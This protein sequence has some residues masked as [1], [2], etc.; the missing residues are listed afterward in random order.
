MNTPNSLSAFFARTDKTTLGNCDREPI[1]LS[2]LVQDNCGLLILD[3]DT[4]VILGASDNI[5][6]FLN[7]ELAQVLTAQLSEVNAEL[8]AELAEMSYDQ[9]RSLHEA[10][11]FSLMRDGTSHDTIV[12]CHNGQLFV[13]FLPNPTPSSN[14]IR[15]KMR[16]C[17]NACARIL[18]ADDWAGSLNIAVDAVR[19]IT[20]FDRV[21]IYQFHSDWS[22]EVI[23]ESRNSAVPSYLGLHFPATDIPK[24]AREIMKLLPSRAIGS[25]SD[26]TARVVTVEHVTRPVDLT[27][28]VSRSVSK[29]HTAYLRNMNVGATFYTSLTHHG[30]LWGLISAH[31]ST[32]DFVPFDSWSL[33]QEIATALM[34]R[35]DQL[36]R[37]SVADKIA[38]LRRIENRF[39]AALRQDGDVER[40][41]QTLVP[42]LQEFLQA[43]GFAFQYG[44]KLH[45]SGSTPPRSFVPQLIQ[46]A[47]ARRENSDQYQTTALHREWEPAAAHIDTA[48]GVLIQPIIMHRVCQLIWF[49]GPITRHVKWAGEQKPKIDPANPLGVLAPRTSFDT[50][51]QEHRDESAPWRNSGLESAREIFKEFLDIIT[52]QFLLKEEN[53]SLRQFAASAA[54]DLKAPLR[55]IT[56]A[57]DIMREEN[58]DEAVVKETHAFAQSSAKRLSDLTSGLL[59]LSGIRDNIHTFRPTDLNQVASATVDLLTAQIDETRARVIIDRLPTLDGNQHLLVRLMLNL[60]GNGLKYRHPDRPPRVHVSV[61]EETP[62]HVEIAFTDNGMGIDPKYTDKIFRPMQRLHAASEIEGSGLGL[63]ICDRIVKVHHGSIQLDPSQADGARFVVHLPRWQTTKQNGNSA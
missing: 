2:G 59:E 30:Q 32:S 61:L 49:R 50:W 34:L 57:L 9:T 43:D 11:E 52:A 18:R 26:A 24:Q 16:L 48:C 40:V 60:I 51:V 31:H 12:H 13:E 10:L 45:L 17:S 44:S 47:M 29:M 42:V 23:A 54:H 28:S 56:Q 41:I 37:T 3:P 58:F 21:K 62:E 35:R 1:H 53:A 36:E 22:G 15:R 63:T 38:E 6:A 7:H 4:H 46:W 27:W 20:G 5:G 55:G 19:E 8:A 33:V 14:L 25:V 39:A